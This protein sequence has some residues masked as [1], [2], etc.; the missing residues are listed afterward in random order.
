M[1]NTWRTSY[2]GF[3]EGKKA[4]QKARMENTLDNLVR[5]DGETMYEKEFALLKLVEGYTPGIE[6]DYSYYSRRLDDYTKPKTRYYIQKENSSYDVTKTLYDFVGYLID[7]GMN[8]LEKA[9]SYAQNEATQLEKQEQDRLE[10][11]TTEKEEQRIKSEKEKQERKDRHEQKVKEWAENGKQYMQGKTIEALRNAIET[12][13]NEIKAMTKTDKHIEEFLNQ[14]IDNYR[15]LFGNS[16]ALKSRVGFT[17]TD[18]V[19]ENNL[20]TK[21]DSLFFGQ[22]F[23]IIEDDKAITATA[24]VTAFL[25]HREYKGA[26]QVELETYYIRVVNKGFEERQGEKKRIGELTFFIGK[27][28]GA[29]KATEARTGSCIGMAKTKAELMK[30]VRTINEEKSEQLNRGISSMIEKFGLSPL[31]T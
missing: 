13:W 9:I 20:Q 10:K 7:T 4:M 17:F 5:V 25:E 18:K 1:K 14:A 26:K 3:T 22:L 16:E 15:G 27:E 31:Y 28:D 29:Y 8:T 21:I 19:N 11:E 30:K 2:L 6:E 23:G 24:K 12:Y